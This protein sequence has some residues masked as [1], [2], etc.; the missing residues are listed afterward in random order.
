M[1]AKVI[2]ELCRIKDVSKSAE[3]R[4]VALEAQRAS[5]ATSLREAHEEA[6]ENLTGME[7]SLALYHT[8]E[9]EHKVTHSKLH[10]LKIRHHLY[11]AKAQDYLRQLS[12]MA[13]VKDSAWA[14][15]FLLGFETFKGFT[16]NPSVHISI[17]SAPSG[18]LS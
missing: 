1:H 7:K 9:A 16:L 14:H 2:Y 12:H 5:L 13:W 4:L 15:G 10:H 8:F 3:L 6:G 18:F 17:D 11:K